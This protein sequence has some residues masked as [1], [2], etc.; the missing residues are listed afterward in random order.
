MCVTWATEVDVL[1][2]VVGAAPQ[3]PGV[4]GQGEQVLQ[5]GRVGDG[6]VQT[7]HPLLALLERGK[8]AS[9]ERQRA[10]I[11]EIGV[12]SQQTLQREKLR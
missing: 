4:V 8:V 9:D 2:L 10:E 12:A 3:A 7:L 6:P 1:V 11:R 5:A